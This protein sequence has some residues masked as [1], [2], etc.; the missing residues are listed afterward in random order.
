[1][2][3]A[4]LQHLIRSAQ[5]LAEGRPMLVLGSASLLASFPDLGNANG[6]LAST[7]DADLCPDPF[8]ELTA[9]MLDEALGEN[10]AYYRIHGYHADI[11]R[12]SILETLP[13]GWRERLVPVPET[14]AAFALDPQD[15]AT[16][17]LLVGRPKDLALIR[18]LHTA[19]LLQ[20]EVIRKR[21]DQLEIPIERMPR[22]LASF[23][24]IFPSK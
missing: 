16:V 3:L 10:R 9:I 1:M 14:L 17:K 4:A 11:L 21:I 7:F 15:L 12:D 23:G 20:P 6:P 2:T 8:D 13:A 5:A 19:A 22:I 24:S 18:E